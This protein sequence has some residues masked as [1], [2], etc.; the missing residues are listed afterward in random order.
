MVLYQE[1]ISYKQNMFIF[2][3]FSWWYVYVNREVDD[4]QVKFPAKFKIRA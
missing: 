2:M 1:V 4:F 3:V